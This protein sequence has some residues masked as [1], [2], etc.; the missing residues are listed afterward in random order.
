MFETWLAEL[1]RA[2]K[3]G[4]RLPAA[5]RGSAWSQTIVIAGDRSTATFRGA[6][7]AQPDAADPPLAAFTVSTPAYDAGTDKTTVAISLVAGT[8]AGSTGILPA[9]GDGD[10][11]EDFPFDVLMTPSGGTEELL[12]GGVLPVAGR[13]TV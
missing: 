13:I 10:G 4:V 3:G 6:V 11:V 12:L 9:D 2:Q 7:K 8:G 1:A 5:R